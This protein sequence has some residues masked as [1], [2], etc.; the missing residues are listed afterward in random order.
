MERLPTGIKGFDELVEG[1]LPSNYSVLVTGAPGTGKSI[2]AL[3]T[4]YNNA[5]A[6]RSGLYVVFGGK[7]SE[8]VLREEARALKMN[9]DAL[10]KKRHIQILNNFKR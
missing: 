7:S 3:Q 1:G 2:F 6:G 9:L 8:N 4:L 10:E 5:V